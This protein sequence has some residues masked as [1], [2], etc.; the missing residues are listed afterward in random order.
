MHLTDTGV[1]SVSR[2]AVLGEMYAHDAIMHITLTY[3]L[4]PSSV[5]YMN[6]LSESYYGNI[7]SCFG[8][9]YS[10][11]VMHISPAFFHALPEA[12]K[13]STFSGFWRR[14]EK[15][16]SFPASARCMFRDKIHFFGS[17]LGSAL[18]HSLSSRQKQKQNL[19][20]FESKV[21]FCFVNPDQTTPYR[22]QNSTF[23][24]LAVK[25]CK[26]RVL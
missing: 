1:F 25:F 23:T 4:L 3:S 14:F 10:P 12:G 15:N 11:N 7:T 6:A 20:K 5:L 21:E 18:G 17:R 9:S 24:K 26:R 2:M 13:K 8:A 16:S 19:I 22:R